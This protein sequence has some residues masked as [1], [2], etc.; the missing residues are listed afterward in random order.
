MFWNSR[1]QVSVRDRLQGHLGRS[2]EHAQIISH[3]IQPFERVNLQIV[4]DRWWDD[5]RGPQLFGYSFVSYGT[6]HGLAY[7]CRVNEQ[8]APVERE[9]LPKKVGESLACVKKGIFLLRYREAPIVVMI[10]PGDSIMRERQTLELMACEATTAQDALKQL[11]QESNQGSVYQGQCISLEKK[12]AFDDAVSLRFIVVEPVNRDSIVLP[13]RI[14]EVLERNVLSSSKHREVL[15]QSGRRLRHG[16]LLHGPPGTGKSLMVRY[17][18]QATR[19]HTVILLSG[20]NMTAIRESCEMA[21]LLAPSMVVLEDADLITEER[22]SNK[23][24]VLLHELMDEMDG[25]GPKADCVFVLTT[26]R[27]QVLEP[28]LAARPGRIDLAIGFPLPDE[29]CR[30]RLFDLYGKGLDLQW[31]DLERWV[32]QTEGVSPAF[33]EGLLRKATLFAAER[34]EATN[35]LQLHNTDIDHALKELTFFGAELTRRMDGPK[36]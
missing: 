32:D 21:R 28:A 13:E 22:S 1:Q 25:I 20:R 10:R 12:N 9:H 36:D 7:L 19:D 2:F 16:L 31:V 6:D 14:M 18:A 23:S 17:L 8:Q 35:P 34:G 3:A 15:R 33:I 5:S 4:L 11:L 26:N 24:P 29:E 30:K 27:P